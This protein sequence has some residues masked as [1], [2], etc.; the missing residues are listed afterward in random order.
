MGDLEKYLK[1]YWLENYLFDEVNRNFQERGYLTPEEFFAIVIWKSNRAKKKVLSGIGE[2][3]QTIRT[4]TSQI[5]ETEAPEE[6]FKIL[7]RIHGIG[8]P[9]ASAILAVCEPKKFTVVDSRAWAALKSLPKEVTGDLPDDPTATIDAYLQYLDKCK[10][11]AREDGVSLRD[12]DRMLWG[13][14]FYDGEN[15]L[16][17]LVKGLEE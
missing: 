13:K 10:E 14:D 15:G 2:S 16:K 12:F 3:G 1:Y 8:I 17:K 5:H 9:I 7:T 4:I 11:L 6:K